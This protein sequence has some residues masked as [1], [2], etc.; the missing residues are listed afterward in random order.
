MGLNKRRVLIVLGI[1]GLMTAGAVGLYAVRFRSRQQ[2]ST[3][4]ASA[5]RYLEQNDFDSA[6]VEVDKL[7]A[8]KPQHAGGHLLKGKILLAG[9]KPSELRTEN[10]DGLAAIR[11]LIQATRLDPEM[12]EPRKLLVE[13]FLSTGDINEAGNHARAVLRHDTDD[14]QA[15]FALGSSLL[16]RRQPQEAS[17]HAD[18]LVKHESPVRPRSAWLAAQLGDLQG[19]ESDL[20][21]AAETLLNEYTSSPREW[22]SI[23][24]ELALVELRAWQARRTDNTEQVRSQTVAA[25]DQLKRM[26]SA[27]QEKNIPPRL[28]LKAAARL[29]PERSQRSPRLATV[30]D[31]LE[32][33]V[34]EL[35]KA[36][37]E[38]AIAI[39]TSDPSIYVSY[40]SKLRDEGQVDKAVEIANSGIAMAKAKGA[41]YRIAFALCDLWLAEH[42]LAN[43]QG[44]K[45]QP[46]LDALLATKHLKGWGQLLTGY[47]LVQKGEFDEAAASLE[48]AVVALPENGTA[49][50]LLGLC[51][52]RRGFVTE[53][54]SYL[55]KGIRLGA[56]DPQYK[57][58][59]AMALAE[60]GY[61]EQA[62]SIA[63]QVLSQGSSRGLGRAL[64]GQLRM[65]SGD[66]DQAAQDFATAL[67]TADEAFRPS[68]VLSQAELAI[69]RDDWKTAQT[70]LEELKQ[71]SLAPQAYAV[72][73]RYL[74]RT[75]QK[76]QA[77]EV[78]AQA[79]QAHPD[80]MLLLA[81]QVSNLVQK[82]EHDAAI[83]LLKAE[84]EKHPESPSPHLLLSEVYELKEE[85]DQALAVL[86]NACAK[87]PDEVPLKIRLIERQLSAGKFQESAQVLAD[88]KGNP[89]VNP[90]TLDYLLARS[91]SLQGEF[92][93]AEEII[94]R[95]SERDPDNPMLK[96]LLGQVA[97]KQ[98]DYATASQL[99][100]QSL[101]GGA[102]REQT[103]HALFESLLRTGETDRAIEL[104]SRA[105]RQG[106]TVRRMR[107]KLLQLLARREKWD[108]LEKELQELLSNDP[109]DKDF[110]LGI[111]LLRFMNRLDQA[112]TL[113][114]KGLE[115]FPESSA[116]LEHQ[117]SLLIEEKKFDDAEKLLTSLRQ[118]KP[119]NPTLHILHIA[120]LMENN[121]LDEAAAVAEEGWK[122][123]GGNRALA[124]LRVQ[125]L[126][127]QKKDQQALEFAQQAKREFED[128]PSPRYLMARM[129][130]AIGE[131]EKA[132]NYL[133]TTVADE[134]T[135]A[136]A[137]E[138]YLRMLMN[139]GP[140]ENF[141][142]IVENL[143]KANPENPVLLGVLAEF[144]VSRGNLDQAET[145]VS[146]IESLKSVGPLASYLKAL[147]A[148][149]RQNIEEAERSLTVAL[150]DP[151]GHIPS[152]YLLARTRVSQGR[153]EEALE[154]LGQVCR[155]Q[156]GLLSARQ[157]QV[158]L[159]VKLNKLQEAEA[160]CREFLKDHPRSRPA[161]QLLAEVLI[162]QGSEQAMQ[163]ALQ[164]AQQGLQE[165]VDNPAQFASYLNVLIACGKQDIARAAVENAEKQGQ[166][167]M[168]L[169][170]TRALLASDDAELARDIAFRLYRRF[171][172]DVECL[173]L[174]G[175]ATT[176]LAKVTG[177]EAGFQ[178]A[179]QHYREVLRLQQGHIAAANN[180]AWTVGVHLKNPH[181]GLEEMIKA[182]PQAK[183]ASPSLPAEVLDTIGTL[184]KD[185]GHLDEAQHFLE[186]ATAR[187]PESAV[188]HFH[189]GLVYEKQGRSTR[190]NQCF[191]LAK[192]LDP[193]GGWDAQAQKA[194]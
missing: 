70:L 22:T 164:I 26:T 103:I 108:L 150:A 193:N 171:P 144:H 106:Y 54:R 182:L 58:W 3:L 143:V 124:A 121:R 55:E 111:S 29:L 135:N 8:L 40:A 41:E 83:T 113:V 192:Q 73:Y 162:K 160:S 18:Y 56:D 163:E 114:E 183:T 20:R 127:L 67:E 122:H 168:V 4:E 141:V 174:L 80:S 158:Q 115:K 17:V 190:A 140:P 142:E 176:K 28:L 82:K 7:L 31:E 36:V 181:R 51:Q 52:L 97:V 126:L 25:I 72:Q 136:Q 145:V 180:L 50:A 76:E 91:A 159:L 161:Q 138:N 173:M 92:T 185:M 81:I 167:G 93:R 10:A 149:S 110:A 32:P 134:P 87:F 14:A 30:Y 155:Q 175:D 37:Y 46:H 74:N 99:F 188:L 118:E 123:C 128:L 119:E 130:E 2:V 79:R 186:A 179:A 75:D 129:Y 44:D 6:K 133:S 152:T 184:H 57:A 137:A 11:S 151:R 84:Q 85:E 42:F 13:Y 61:Q 146:R 169:S 24:D 23:D 102:F 19:W 89:K 12:L 33:S 94:K 90:A 187:K 21:K 62:V 172:E 139:Q 178:Q 147:I 1:M 131:D 9:R 104:L 86:E 27:L 68:L 77:D 38:Q 112:R 78:L 64:L 49:N 45:A 53:G 16:E 148:F 154:L 47:R 157:L 117:I 132:L 109:E 156:S 69:V 66:Y 15:R 35:T 105:Q 48:E 165:G 116:L 39:Q 170:G 101:A 177:D 59:L 107:G 96:F 95:A 191:A 88:L 125:V 194:Q 65:R 63:Q 34:N 98:G 100:E 120:L 60:A 71:T 43:R 5:A 166:T 189:L 153:F